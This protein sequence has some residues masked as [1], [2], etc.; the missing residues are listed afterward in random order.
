MNHGPGPMSLEQIEAAAREL[1]EAEMEL[2]VERLREQLEPP[3]RLSGEWLE[4]AE[5]RMEEVDRGEVET[6]PADETIAKLRVIT[7]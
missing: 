7:R 2:L 5:R 4:E 1:P 6:I 3:A